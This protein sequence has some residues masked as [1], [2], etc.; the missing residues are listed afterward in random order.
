[1]VFFVDLCVCWLHRDGGA[2]PAVWIEA[3]SVDVFDGWNGRQQLWN[4]L[5]Q[6]LEST[7]AAVS[8]PESTRHRNGQ[9]ADHS[10]QAKSQLAAFSVI[11]RALTVRDCSWS[12]RDP[13]MNSG[14]CW[15]IYSEAETPNMR[16]AIP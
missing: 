13:R 15:W 12:V 14:F 7:A 8:R 3:Y 11:I 1:V 6:C 2:G 5:Q 16:D 10:T 9:E 4:H